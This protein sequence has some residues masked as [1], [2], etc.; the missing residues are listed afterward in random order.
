MGLP[1]AGSFWGRLSWPR[2]VPRGPPAWAGGPILC[3]QSGHVASP[4]PR[5]LG[6]CP[7]MAPGDCRPPG[8][9]GALLSLRP[10]DG[11]RG[12]ACSP[13]PSPCCDT[14]TQ[15]RSGSM[16]RF[17]AGGGYYSAYPTC[18]SKDNLDIFTSHMR[19]T[20]F[21]K[22]FLWILG[23]KCCRVKMS[24]GGVPSHLGQ[25]R[26]LQGF[27]PSPSRAAA[28]HDVLPDLCSTFVRVF[29]T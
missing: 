28:L 29:A 24:R 2:P 23:K 4:S 18:I 16:D 17:M 14:F 26:P 5:R 3:F 27:P 21:F 22:N 8:H 7:L 19:E 11:P 1:G 20:F 6:L 15:S 13:H 10:S 9:A 25:D 12:S